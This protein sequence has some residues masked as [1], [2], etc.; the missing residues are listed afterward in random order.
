EP[1]RDPRLGRNEEAYS[2]DPYLSARIADTI[3]RAVQGNDISAPDKTVA[4]L[5]H[6]PGQSQPVGG[7]ER[8]AMD[9][10]ERMLREVFL[11]P[12]VAGVRDAGALGVMAT[13]PAIDGVPAHASEKILTSILREELG[14]EG[15]VLGEGSGIQTLVYERVARDQKHAGQIALRAGVD[16]GISYES[17]YMLD[18]IE[19]VNE[20]R[21][22]MADIDRAV[23][24]ILT[25]K[26]RLGL[27]EKPYVNPANA[28]DGVPRDKHRALA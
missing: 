5:C 21:A 11:P 16:V 27:F 28:V 17:G 14:F 15:L 7:M 1:T 13:Y 24:R 10:S 4:G 19:S 3:V 12:W 2:E 6:Y 20:G 23:R 9:I 25:L 26:F 8:G 18:M 22:A